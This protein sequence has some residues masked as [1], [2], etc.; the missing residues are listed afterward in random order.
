MGKGSDRV[1][2]R[3]QQSPVV[4]SM[5]C[6]DVVVYRLHTNGGIGNSC[7]ITYV[8]DSAFYASVYLKKHIITDVN[9]KVS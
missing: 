4:S 8:R 3:N 1:G 5:S 2:A 7:T 6:S 9:E